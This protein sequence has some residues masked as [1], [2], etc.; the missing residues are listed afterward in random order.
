MLDLG[1]PRPPTWRTSWSTP[2]RTRCTWT[3][4]SCTAGQSREQ[5]GRQGW[6][7]TIMNILTAAPLIL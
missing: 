1:P 5:A 7:R 6:G 2:W 3:R 4:Q